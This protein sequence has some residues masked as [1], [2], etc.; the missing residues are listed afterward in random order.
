MKRCLALA[1]VCV[2]FAPA[3]APAVEDIAPEKLLGKWELTEK[4]AGFPK[5]T[6]FDFQTGGKLVITVEINGEA[7]MTPVKY[8]LKERTLRLTAGDKTD[9]TEATYDP[10]TGEL[11]C[12]DK[13]GTTARFKRK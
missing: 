11:V 13:D 5:G 10:R 12:K 2:L 6:V 1:A 7:K 4:A 9:T 3:A 8:E